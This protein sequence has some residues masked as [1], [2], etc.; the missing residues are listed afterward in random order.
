MNESYSYYMYNTNATVQYELYKVFI[1]NNE[2]M[3]INSLLTL[4][5]NT[6]KIIKYLRTLGIENFTIQCSP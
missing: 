6:Y 5:I 4:G 1:N 3:N 2:V